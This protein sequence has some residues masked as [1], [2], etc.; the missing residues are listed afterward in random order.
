[1][2]T[3][4]MSVGPKKRDSKIFQYL[5]SYLQIR[6]DFYENPYNIYLTMVLWLTEGC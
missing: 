6:R 1:M 4:K 2:T 5:V 3:F